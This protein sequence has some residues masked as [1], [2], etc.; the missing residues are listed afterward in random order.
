MHQY[1]DSGLEHV[2]LDATTRQV[3]RQ[4]RRVLDIQRG[5]EAWANLPLCIMRTHKN[6]IQMTA[7]HLGDLQ[8]GIGQSFQPYA[9]IN[10]LDSRN[11]AT[12]SQGED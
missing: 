8:T 5:I 4:M 2:S 11:I 12:T 9:P 3:G 10:G 7:H 6:K 1:G